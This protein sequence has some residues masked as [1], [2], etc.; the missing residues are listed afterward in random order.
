MELFYNDIWE[1]IIDKLDRKTWMNLRLTCRKLNFLCKIVQI[2]QQKSTILYIIIPKI[3]IGCGDG[4]KPYHVF[5]SPPIFPIVIKNEIIFETSVYSF[6][7]SLYD[8]YPK[9]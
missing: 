7:I 2:R 8:F 3:R 1:L 9:I 4:I 5:L 6:P